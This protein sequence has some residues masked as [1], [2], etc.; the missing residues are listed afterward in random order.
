M[1]FREVTMIEIKE[2]LRQWL[3]GGSRKEI[4]RRLRMDRNTV[5]GYIRLAESHGLTRGEG[6]AALTDER[7]LAIVESVRGSPERTH[8]AAWA[9]CGEHRDFIAAKLGERVRLS[10]VHKLLLRQGVDVPYATLHRFAVAELE[11]GRGAATIPVADCEPG[12]ELQV[13]TGWVGW[14]VPLDGKRRRIRAWIFTAVRS[15]HRFVYPCF[16]E[17]TLDAIEA[18]EAAWEFFGGVFRVLVPDNTKAIVDDADPLDPFINLAF[19]EYA[20]ARGFVIDPA[21]A[22]HPRDKARVERAVQSVRDDCFG[23]ETLRSLDDARGWARTWCLEAYGMRRHTRTGRMPLEQFEA[24]EK[25]RLLPVPVSPY[26]VP[27]WCTPK[28][29][30]LGARQE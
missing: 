9:R 23:G 12:Q 1:A 4:A 21:R 29:A 17:T 26:E 6:D 7:L 16:R 11:F 20:Q 30:R 14:I 19:L 2:V 13:D 22:R 5:R 25:E 3:T 27:F 8:G 15:R 28:V 10:K 18:C 24:E